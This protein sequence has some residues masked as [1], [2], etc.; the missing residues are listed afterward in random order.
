MISTHAKLRDGPISPSPSPSPSIPPAAYASAKDTLLH[1]GVSLQLI[2]DLNARY[3]RRT[4]PVMNDEQFFQL[5]SGVAID[6]EPAAI[7]SKIQT[8]MDEKN[9]SIH[10]SYVAAKYE[11]GLATLDLFQ[12]VAQQ[13]RY[14][15][16][17]REHTIHNFEGFV[18]DCLP[19]LIRSSLRKKTKSGQKSSKSE[20][21]SRR[22]STRIANQNKRI[23]K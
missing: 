16:S 9:T 12:S 8:V 17:L 18:A 15:S 14:L 10:Y 21:K 23:A 7:E 3:N 20:R 22:R 19:T 1:R 5:L 6:S 4:I 13:F 2:D 11:I